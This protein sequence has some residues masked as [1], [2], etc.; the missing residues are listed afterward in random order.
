MSPV[1]PPGEVVADV[2]W[3]FAECARACIEIG[4]YRLASPWW[5]VVRG[6]F[7]AII[8]GVL[9]LAILTALGPDVDA[10]TYLAGM[11][12]WMFFLL[13]FLGF[14]FGGAGW[15]GAWQIRR[16]NPNMVAGMK[17]SI[18]SEA[19]RIRCGQ[20]ESTA[21]WGG[22]LRVVE[23]KRFFLTF[24]IRTGAYYLPKRVLTQDQSAAVRLIA[25]HQASDRF[26]QRAV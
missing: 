3:Q 6:A 17:H 5:R 11:A 2:D 21:Q 24:P 15:L 10:G 9:V 26:L 16:N 14:R 23:T 4:K 13:L 25:Q 18:S 1:S 12:P 19:Y 22:I 20:V 7:T 8:V